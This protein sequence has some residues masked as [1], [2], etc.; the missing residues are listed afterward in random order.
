MVVPLALLAALL[1]ALAGAAQQRAAS[2]VLRAPAAAY[3]GAQCGAG[4]VWWQ[5]SAPARLRR[6]AR[7]VARLAVGLL[8]SPLWLA[9]WAADALAFATQAFAVHVGSLLVVQPLLVTTLLFSLPLAM[10]GTR[11][12]PRGRDWAGAVA[13]CVGLALILSGQHPPATSHAHP[14]RVLVLG[15]LLAVAA[16]VLVLAARARPSHR[17]AVPLAV[18]AGM[19]AAM[20]AALMKL[21]GDSLTSQGVAATASSWPGYALI[22]VSAGGLVAQQAAFSAGSLPATMTAITITGPLVSYLLGIAGFG[23]HAPHGAGIAPAMLGLAALS[24]GIA[25]LARSPL[26][27]PPGPAAPGPVHAAGGRARAGPGSCGAGLVR[28][29]TPGAARTGVG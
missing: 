12:R 29:R 11:L 18:V 26:L 13:A 15:L 10:P 23:E 6:R 21:I 4:C 25:V 16:A 14:A 22:A 28:G 3:C 9:G 20:G 7:R 24:A 17:R 5:M 2:R 19:A 8:H 1:Y 27:A